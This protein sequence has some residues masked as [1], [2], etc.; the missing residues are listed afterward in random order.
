MAVKTLPSGFK[1]RAIEWRLQ[2]PAQVNRSGY[3]GAR[4]VVGLPGGARWSASVEFAPFQN[5]AAVRAWR[6]FLAGLEGQV[7]TFYMPAV[8]ADQH[9]GANPTATVASGASSATLSSS[10]GLQA[11]QYLTFTLSSGKRQMVV[12]TADMVGA[13]ATFRPPLREAA[14][15]TVET[16]RPYA[17]VALTEDTVAWSPQ[18]GGIYALGGIEVEEAY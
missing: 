1:F 2:Q 13:L 11:G 15:G 6:G 4:Q 18:P 8:L 5:D 3:T 16:L 12:L 10:I 14:T 17:Q 9:A 7:H